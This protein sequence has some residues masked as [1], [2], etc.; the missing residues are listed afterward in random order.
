MNRNDFSDYHAEQVRAAS[1]ALR[2][3][4]P[5]PGSGEELGKHA[6]DLIDAR[7][8]FAEH[9]NMLRVALAEAEPFHRE[10]CQRAYGACDATRRDPNCTTVN[11]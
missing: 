5:A 6:V 9:V 3:S 2:R 4:A 8:R 10:I 1:A 11:P 7:D